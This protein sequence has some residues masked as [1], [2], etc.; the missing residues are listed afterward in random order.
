M[1]NLQD[2][3]VFDLDDPDDCMDLARYH[4]M[5]NEQIKMYKAQGRFLSIPKPRR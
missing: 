2:R 4:E 3:F 1:K 5:T